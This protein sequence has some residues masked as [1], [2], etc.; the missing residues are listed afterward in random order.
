MILI[1]F[2]CYFSSN[3]FFILTPWNMMYNVCMHWYSELSD[4]ST[5][6]PDIFIYILS[7][8]CPICIRY[9]LWDILWQTSE[10]CWIFQKKNIFYTD[11]SPPIHFKYCSGHTRHQKQDIRHMV[12]KVVVKL[13]RGYNFCLRARSIWT[14]K[15][16]WHEKTG[17]VFGNWYNL[18]G[19]GNLHIRSCSPCHNCHVTC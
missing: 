2:P 10:K 6:W 1:V 16:K 5:Q 13:S 4:L 9:I 18:V 7:S 8:K 11:F 17:K 19:Q 3:K 14:I 12:T 15:S